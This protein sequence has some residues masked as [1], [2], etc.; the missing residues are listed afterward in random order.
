MTSAPP[1]ATHFHSCGLFGLGRV[2]ACA[3]DERPVYSCHGVAGFLGRGAPVDAAER[4]AARYESIPLAEDCGPAQ[5]GEALPMGGFPYIRH[6]E[7]CATICDR[8]RA[9]RGFVAAADDASAHRAGA[10]RLMG[11]PGCY[12]NPYFGAT[13]AYRQRSD[14]A[15]P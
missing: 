4:L 15:T 9:C 1:P 10:C 14:D 13:S 6:E 8:V 5:Q 3:A 11:R 12:A 7:E 2:P